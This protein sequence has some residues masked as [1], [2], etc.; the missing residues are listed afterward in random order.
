M[1][2]ATIRGSTATSSVVLPLLCRPTNAI[3]GAFTRDRLG[4][5]RGPAAHAELRAVGVRLAAVG[6]VPSR[7]GRRLRLGGRR[8]RDGG[9]VLLLGLLA[10]RTDAAAE[11]AEHGG[12]LPRAEHDEHDDEDEDEL[13]PANIERHG[14]F[15]VRARRAVSRLRVYEGDHHP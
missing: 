14:H 1:P 13:R 10:E 2:R 9:A 7:R 6:A 3:R 12:E 5:E 11:L 15:L 8:G 4:G